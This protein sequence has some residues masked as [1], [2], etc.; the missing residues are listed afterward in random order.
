MSRSWHKSRDNVVKIS[1]L[2]FIDFDAA[3]NTPNFTPLKKT[4]IQYNENLIDAL[5]WTPDLII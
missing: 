3:T 4:K 5:R 1:F 2:F